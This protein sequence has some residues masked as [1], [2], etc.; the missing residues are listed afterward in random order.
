MMDEAG[1]TARRFSSPC[2]SSPNINVPREIR[3]SPNPNLPS[4]RSFLAAG[5]TGGVLAAGYRAEAQNGLPADA[6]SSPANGVPP[7]ELSELSI[8]DLQR[9]MASGKFTSRSL[10]ERYLARIDAVDA[11]GPQLKS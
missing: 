8:D 11:A 2:F 5:V 4:R 6:A 3:F 9:G 10:V 7:F 1:A